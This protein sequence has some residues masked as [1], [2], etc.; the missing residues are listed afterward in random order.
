MQ[1]KSER[2]SGSLEFVGVVVVAVILVGGV[3]GAVAASDP[4]IRESI[5]TRICQIIGGNCSA[6]D[7]PRNAAVKP[8]ACDVATSNENVNA[9]VDVAFV[10]LQGGGTLQRVT[11]SNGD[12]EV[13]VSGEGHAGVVAS[14][15]ARGEVK[16][17]ESTFGASAE[18]E[19]AATLG[20]EGGETFVFQ[21]AE[22]A[23]AFQGYM[24]QEFGEEAVGATNPLFRAANWAYEGIT[25]Q[26]APENDGVQKWYVQ[27]EAGGEVTANAS[28]GY[29]ASVEGEA[30]A[31]R[32][33]GSEFDRGPDPDSRVDDTRTDYYQLNWEASANATL[34]AVKGMEAS[35]ERTGIIKVT[36]NEEREPVK[37]EFIDRSTGSLDVGLNASGSRDGGGGSAQPVRPNAPEVPG[38]QNAGVKLMAGASN[39]SVVVTQTLDLTE[40]R[41]RAAFDDWYNAANAIMSTDLQTV[42][43]LE[44]EKGEHVV[45]MD[46]DAASSFSEV[47]SRQGKTSIVEYDGE[48]FGLGVAAEAGLGL[49]AGIDIGGES[50]S[51]DAVEAH[52]LGAPES[53]GSRPLL[54]L[55]ECLS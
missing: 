21:D 52:Y 27:A 41:A 28:A 45:G 30:S 48:T 8:E 42:P 36:R 7:A 2:G 40:P 5:W 50:S 16:L 38:L 14:V 53:D 9:T 46:G 29:G 55:P 12:I 35:A 18:A 13:T 17:G 49:K 20:M 54:E 47:L 11:K 34:P 6:A 24:R 4:V 43:G 39:N 10:R 19:A 15:G 1:R 26:E 33:L 3:V 31:M 51:T 23:D 22:K 44:S 37:V 25:Q 32:A